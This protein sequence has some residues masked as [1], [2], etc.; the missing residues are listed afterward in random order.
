MNQRQLAAVTIGVFV[1]IIAGAIAWYFAHPS[2]QLQT[3]SQSPIV[4]KA[5]V[6]QPAPQFQASTTDGLFDLAKTDKPV[7]LEVFA[8]WCPHCQRE[9]AVIDKLYAAYGSRVAFVAVSGSGT[10]MDGTSESSP[11]DV[12]NFAQQFNVRYP[13]A[14]DPSI[15]EPND[16][17]SV[18][19]LYLQGGFPSFAIIGKD[20][21]VAYL[22][23]GEISYNDLAA[24][25]NNVLR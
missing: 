18:A 1:L 2:R 17:K 22:N 14:Y 4:G 23:S 24:Q 12:L 19:N 13:I 5:Q 7:F 25:L 11:L 6:G 15:R 3:A 9:T 20:K 16:P 10:A 8:T 21:K